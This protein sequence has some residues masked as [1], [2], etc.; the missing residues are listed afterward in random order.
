MNIDSILD[1]FETDALKYPEVIEG[2]YAYAKKA[3]ESLLEYFRELKVDNIIFSLT[4]TDS[5]YFRFN[6]DKFEV[7]VDSFYDNTEILTI[8]VIHDIDKCYA[9]Y[10]SYNLNDI[11]NKIREVTIGTK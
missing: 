5:L 8:L 11:F 7:T 4:H 3:L 2:N 9:R 1:K 6:I 10:Y